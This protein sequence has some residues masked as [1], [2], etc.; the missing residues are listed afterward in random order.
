M[1]KN[2]LKVSKKNP[3][4]IFVITYVVLFLVN[5]VV[6]HFANTW[7]PQQV[8]LGTMSLS[9]MWALMLSA[10]KIAL[11][12]T[13]VLPFLTQIEIMRNKIMS[14]IEMMI[15][16]AIINIVA[17]WGTTRFAEVFGLGVSS[18]VVVVVLALVLDFVQGV[19]MVA[20]EMM[21]KKYLV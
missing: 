10:G 17:I 13:L 14:P 11:I 3:G 21:R 1:P 6:I 5:M 9:V 4:M 7:F 15:A 19:A 18:I 20:L 16:Y 2:E 12:D 8:V